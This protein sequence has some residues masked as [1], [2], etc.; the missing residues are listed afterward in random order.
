MN[1]PTVWQI[2]LE[3]AALGSIYALV[4]AGIVVIFRA[5]GL[6]NFAQGQFMALAGYIGYTIEHHLHLSYPLT[7]VTTI[8]IVFGAGALTYWAFLRPLL[9]FP[10]WAPIMVTVGLSIVL[11][12][13]IDM[14]WQQNT[15]ELSG[16]Q[17]ISRVELGWAAALSN[18]AIANIAAA[19]VVLVAL[20]LILIRT[21]YG[22]RLQAAAENPLLAGLAGIKVPRYF[23]LA[24]GIGGGAAAIAGLGYS[25][26][27]LV[28][29][30]LVSLGL[31]A[32]PAALVGGMDSVRGAA[33]GGFLV[34]LT[35][36]LGVR[37]FGSAAA[38]AT[39]FLILLLTLTARPYG[40][41]GSR[42]VARV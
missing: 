34:A 33:L 12:S 39:V 22:R 31:R 16:F 13:V 32:F 26:V 17:A 8:A 23:A 29:P 21:H 38:D 20:E 35:E 18:A 7:A 5:T 6:F 14:V 9:G 28:T 11:D 19:I 37:L 3:T 2:L 30:T 24:W 27:A 15:F 36:V 10:L 40:F 42:E 41:L 25:T 1:W 4:A